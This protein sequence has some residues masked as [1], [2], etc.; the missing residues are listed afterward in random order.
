MRFVAYLVTR[1]FVLRCTLIVFVL[2]EVLPK[3][4]A[5]A[6]ASAVQDFYVPSADLCMV[7]KF[8]TP[9]TNCFFFPFQIFYTDPVKA[10]GIDTSSQTSH[11]DPSCLKRLGRD[12]SPVCTLLPNRDPPQTSRSAQ[13]AP[14]YSFAQDIRGTPP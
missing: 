13:R 1:K 9:T 2:P 6:F 5:R 12:C 8:Y 10:V 3:G 4:R 11:F 7:G 14:D